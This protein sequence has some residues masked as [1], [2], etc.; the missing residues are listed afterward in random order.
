[1]K[2][3][4]NIAIIAGQLVVG[5]AER[6]LYMW[7]SNLDR[8]RYNPIVLTLHP[9]HDDYWEK[10]IES[11]GIPLIRISQ[12]RNRIKR[13]REIIKVL[14]SHNPRLIHGWH[15]FASVYAGL[16][17]KVLKTKSIGGVR[18]TYRTFSNH[19]LEVK[20]TTMTVDALVVNSLSTTELLKKNIRNEKQQ[21]YAV[22]N[23]VEDHFL[24]RETS[25]KKL[26]EE[27]N[28]PEECFWI[29]SMGRMDPLKRFDILLKV[30]R[31]L[32]DE[33]RNIHLFLIGDGP[34]KAGLE[35]QSQ[36]LFINDHVTFSGEVGGAS[37]WLKAFDLFTFT[38]T[39]EGMPNVIMEA[40]AAGL[41]IVTWQLPFY[42]E[43][44]Q[45]EK[46]ALLVEAGNII[47]MKNAIL[48][49]IESSELRTRIGQAAREHI[50]TTFR[51]DRF[52]QN[53]TDVY[54]SVLTMSSKTR[55]KTP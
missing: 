14:R 49:L 36:E 40:A 8:D 16:A 18:N 35:N 34:E 3:K 26:I 33:T 21:V 25:R 23:A 53:M 11:L 55:R 42:E 37:T 22:Q 30:L 1:M 29:G 6:Q 48:R 44:L 12:H 51:V 2:D 4:I 19:G 24:D 52:I 43:L 13:L 32:N 10:P 31:L 27:Y 5:G 38:S 28:L 54:E 46:T 20:L 39:D 50:L 17:S 45:N 9:G 47:E 15:L 7:L 41:P